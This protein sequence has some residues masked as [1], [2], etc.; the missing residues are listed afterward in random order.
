MASIALTRVPATS[1]PSARIFWATSTPGVEGGWISSRPGASNR[2]RS[3]QRRLYRSVAGD[4]RFS[5]LLRHADPGVLFHRLGLTPRRGERREQP[6]A[7]AVDE[8]RRAARWASGP[9]SARFRAPCRASTGTPRVPSAAGNPPESPREPSLRHASI[10]SSGRDASAVCDSDQPIDAAFAPELLGARCSDR[11][12]RRARRG[13]PR[14][15]HRRMGPDHRRPAG[16]S[17]LTPRRRPRRRR[18]PLSSGRE[19]R[20]VPRGPAPTGAWPVNGLARLARLP[21]LS[22]ASSRPSP[23]FGRRRPEHRGPV[24]RSWRPRRCAHAPP[25]PAPSPPPPPR[26]RGSADR[27]SSWSRDAARPS[28]SDGSPAQ[29]PRRR[30]ATACT[31]P[32][33]CLRERVASGLPESRQHRRASRRPRSVRRVRTHTRAARLRQSCRFALLQ[34]A[35][36]SC[37]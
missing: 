6:D 35:R 29:A 8:V 23:A 9:R 26:L 18:S 11:G 27:S 34:A 12:A 10:T 3:E 30:A 4:L 25:P 16:C 15:L 2:D 17:R 21:G 33:A 36:N 14:I 24:P 7:L 31:A 22:A 13:D 1:R 20:S 32:A 37:A 5:A 19:A 28:S